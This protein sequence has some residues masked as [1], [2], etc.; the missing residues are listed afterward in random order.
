MLF[1]SV[2]F[3]ADFVI[4]SILYNIGML[5]SE[6]KVCLGKLFGNEMTVFT[7]TDAIN[8]YLHGLS[9]HASAVIG[10]VPHWRWNVTWS[11]VIT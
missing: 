4:R 6:T 11:S 1:F 9:D 7:S 3:N 8:L 2:K 10:S 5:I